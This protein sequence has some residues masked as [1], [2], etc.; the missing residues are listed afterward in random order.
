[1]RKDE[2]NETNE[3]NRMDKRMNKID[4]KLRRRMLKFLDNE[5]EPNNCSIG[6]KPGQKFF[7]AFNPKQRDAFEKAY[8]F[9]D[10][11]QVPIDCGYVEWEV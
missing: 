4:S 11:G 8:S 7:L 5:T 1:M 10:W 6:F 3:T 9:I 2:T